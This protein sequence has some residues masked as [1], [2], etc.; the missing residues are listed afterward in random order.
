M[1]AD[2]KYE[3]MFLNNY[4]HALVSADAFSSNMPDNPTATIL[5]RSYFKVYSPLSKVLGPCV[6]FGSLNIN[7]IRD[8][9]NYSAPINVLN[10]VIRASNIYSKEETYNG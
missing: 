4:V 8:Y 3:I 6:I 9:N 7:F 2:S 1:F 10:S 5:F